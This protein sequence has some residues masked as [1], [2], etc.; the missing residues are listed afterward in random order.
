MP[1][2]IKAGASPRGMSYFIRAA[3]V[4]AWLENRN[5]LL[6]EDMQAVFEVTIAH[7]IFL[8]PIYEYRKDQLMP[9]LIKGILN[10]VAAP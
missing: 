7:R 10:R 2:L 3:K 5:M 1:Q 4:R 9:S 6:P 8:N